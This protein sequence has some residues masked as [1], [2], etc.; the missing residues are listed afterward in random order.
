M[1]FSQVWIAIRATLSNLRH[2]CLCEWKKI[3]KLFCYSIFG[4]SIRTKKRGKT[5]MDGN[6][7]TIS[8][9]TSLS[10]SDSSN[11]KVVMAPLSSRLT[12]VNSIPSSRGSALM[13]PISSQLLSHQKVDP[14]RKSI[15][16][17]SSPGYWIRILHQPSSKCSMMT[18]KNL[19]KSPISRTC[20]SW[21]WQ[22]PW[23]RP[24]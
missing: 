2:V 1:L 23:H 7:V 12:G 20:L 21:P 14:G 3:G 8:R 9:V 13:I 6:L 5:P 15:T 4:Y 18:W 24:R 11:L 17:S 10:A 19:S 16:E 22:S